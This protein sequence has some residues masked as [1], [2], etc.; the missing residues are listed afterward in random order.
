L[1]K[2]ISKT[3]DGNGRI[4]LQMDQHADMDAVRF[5]VSTLIRQVLGERLHSVDAIGKDL[6][7]LTLTF[8]YVA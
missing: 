8:I 7:L 6:K 4:T 3:G 1:Q 5:E 2:L